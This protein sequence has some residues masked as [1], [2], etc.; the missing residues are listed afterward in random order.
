MK[1]RIALCALIAFPALAQESPALDPEQLRAEAQALR[2]RAKL[3][4][5]EADQTKAA[6]DRLCYEKLLVAHCLDEARR[7]RQEAERAIRRL[8]LEAAALERRLR[9]YEYDLKQ[10]ARA[11][12]ARAADSGA[13]TAEAPRS[14]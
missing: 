8:E 6:A 9:Q 1:A 14:P 2:Q 4:R 10:A 3:M 11:E 5:A 7:A 13:T 12:K